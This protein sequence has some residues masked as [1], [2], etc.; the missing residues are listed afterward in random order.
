M[1]NRWNGGVAMKNLRF[2][3]MTLLGAGLLFLPPP[4]SAQVVTTLAGSGAAGCA[5]GIGAE[6]SFAEPRAVA[7]DSAGH[8]PR[9]GD[10]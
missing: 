6:A 4:A 10:L 5:D 8:R 9:K 1:K 7:A 2:V 3:V